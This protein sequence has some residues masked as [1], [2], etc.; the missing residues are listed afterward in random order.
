MRAKLQSKMR[1]RPRNAAP[2]S[3]VRRA[4]RRR[5]AAPH[6]ERGF[7]EFVAPAALGA[8][9]VTAAGFIGQ[10]RKWSPEST[11]LIVMGTGLATAWFS[12]DELV[13]NVASGAAATGATQLALS[14][15]ARSKAQPEQ[16]AQAT[17][18]QRPSNAV[19]IPP[20]A[21]QEALERVR[22]GM[23]LRRETEEPFDL[24][25]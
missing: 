20:D 22:I 9:A 10:A 7:G 23:A 2:R 13:K 4:S 24:A 3:P 12:D 17:S 5:N 1:G 19:D 18:P 25:D 21:V 11:A 16:V 6:V 8:A 15:F 14:T